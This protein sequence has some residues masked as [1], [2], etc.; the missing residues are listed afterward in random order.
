F[1]HSKSTD[2]ERRAFV[3]T[4]PGYDQDSSKRYPVL[5]LQHGWGENAY[6]WG[7]QGRAAWIIVNLFA[8]N[9]T[10]PFSSGRSYGMTNDTRPG[11]LTNFGIEPPETVRVDESIPYIEADFRTIADQPHRAMA[12]L[13]M[14][15]METKII[16][17]RNLDKFSH[18]GLFSG[19][20]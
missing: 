15:G 6:G 1:F 11:G 18:I 8:E 3:Y 9:K 19:G 7:V 12:G 4:P 10:R 20:S 14:G 17:L 5:D 13:P 16:M 2:T